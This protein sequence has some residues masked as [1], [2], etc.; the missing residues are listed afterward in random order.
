MTKPKKEFLS[1]EFSKR[2]DL[3]RFNFSRSREREFAPT[4]FIVI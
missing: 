4:D 1:A 2:A 3:E